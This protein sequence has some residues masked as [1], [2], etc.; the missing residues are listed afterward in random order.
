M[1]LLIL[2]SGP[3]ARSRLGYGL[4]PAGASA[5]I[6]GDLVHREP[7]ERAFLNAVEGESF[8]R[9]LD[10]RKA[11]AASLAEAIGRRDRRVRV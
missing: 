3:P 5:R 6:K 10:R 11:E 2:I 4:P 1:V 9:R 7:G 8:V